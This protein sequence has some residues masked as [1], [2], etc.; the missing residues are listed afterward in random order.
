MTL[1]STWS[2]LGTVQQRLSCLPPFS[3]FFDVVLAHWRAPHEAVALHR[4]CTLARKQGARHIVVEAAGGRS[5]LTA[6]VDALD[7]LHGGGGAA[8]C[9]AISFFSE[10]D[11]ATPIEKLLNETLIGQVVIVNYRAPGSGVFSISYIYE[12]VLRP[13]SLPGAPPQLMNNY[14]CVGKDFE[15]EVLGRQFKTAGIYY[16]QQN[17]RTHVC[18]HASLRMS[19]NGLNGNGATITNDAINQLLAVTPPLQGLSLGDI[20]KTIEDLGG[21]CADVVDCDGLDSA[22]YMKILASIVESGDRAM[23]V[24]TTGGAEEHVVS[25]YGHTRNSDEWHPQAIPAYAGPVSAPFYSSS[26]WIDHFLIHDDNFGPY[27]TLSSRALE[28]DPNVKAHW[29]IAIRKTTADV[30]GDLAETVSSIHLKNTLPLL[31]PLMPTARWLSYAATVNSPFVLRA[32][33]LTRAEYVEHIRSATCH[34][35][36]AHNAADLALFQQ[37]PDHFWMVE[38]S[39]PALYTGNRSKLGEVLIIANRPTPPATSDYLLG[40]RAPGI[41]MLGDQH[42]QGQIFAFGLQAHSPVYRPNRPL[43]EW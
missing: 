32:V 37:L 43:H 27:Y 9:I 41:L 39:L 17:S 2:L 30:S 16:C 6:D 31:A 8:E 35:G 5:A 11:D 1:P 26:M 38:F 3:F 14:F 29:I 24:F 13:P 4:I 7:K 25:V 28:T 15:I 23:L 42:G 34:D 40:I 33:L 20:V 21:M 36:S 18:A 22:T 19:L 12:A 10:G